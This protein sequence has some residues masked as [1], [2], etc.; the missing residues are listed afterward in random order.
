[1]AVSPAH[2]K[3]RGQEAGKKKNPHIAEQ[4]TENFRTIKVD[5]FELVV[6]NAEGV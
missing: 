1:V 4:Q 6:V 5:I 3:R 2:Q